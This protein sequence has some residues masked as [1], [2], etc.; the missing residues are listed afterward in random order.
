MV[1]QTLG[2][3]KR[4]TRKYFFYITLFHFEYKFSGNYILTFEKMR[5]VAI[6]SVA[7]LLSCVSAEDIQ[8]QSARGILRV[9]DECTKSEFGVMPCL[10]KKAINFIDRVSRMDALSLNDEIR[11]VKN[12]D[13]PVSNAVNEVE[14]ENSLPRGLEARDEKLTNLLVDRLT[15][16]M[17]SRT[18]QIS[19]PAIKSEELSR[20][21]EEG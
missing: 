21:L 15:N 17:S 4:E 3:L 10:K 19:M 11:I 16:F 6:V 2:E 13:A 9:Y 14:L 7:I 12:E 20:S 18:I 8:S 1:Q 5:L